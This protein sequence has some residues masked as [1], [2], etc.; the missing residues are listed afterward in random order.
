MSTVASHWPPGDHS[1][2]IGLNSECSS[3]KTTCRASAWSALT[4]ERNGQLWAGW[5]VR[6]VMMW[7]SPAEMSV[8]SHWPPAALPCML[9]SFLASLILMGAPN[10]AMCPEGHIPCQLD[11]QP[12]H[13][14]CMEYCSPCYSLIIPVCSAPAMTASLPC[15]SLHPPACMA[16]SV[17]WHRFL[18][19]LQGSMA[20]LPGYCGVAIEQVLPGATSTNALAKP[21]QLHGPMIPHPC[22]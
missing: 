9:A 21:Q 14:R 19:L 3:D 15:L 12:L 16:P 8:A 5:P 22:I 10:P 4:P 13:L 2:S 7:P 11:K 20:T 1:D 6:L 17:S 18:P